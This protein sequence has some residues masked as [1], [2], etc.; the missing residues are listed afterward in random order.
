MFH[1]IKFRDILIKI[2]NEKFDT[3]T[4]FALKS[5]VNRT[6]LSQYINGLLNAPPS[7]KILKKIADVSEGITTYQELMQI[8]G[9]IN[10]EFSI[11]DHLSAEEYA[12]MTKKNGS[13]S[14]EEKAQ[15]MLD[16]ME[17]NNLEHLDM[18]PVYG[19]IPAGQPKLAKQYIENMIPIDPRLSGKDV[20][21]YFY[22][23]VVGNS[24]NQKFQDGD[25]VL[26]REQPNLENGEIGA[27]LVNGDDATIKR[28]RKI[29]KDLVLLEPMSDDSSFEPITIDLKKQNLKI[30]GKAVNYFGSL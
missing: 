21:N 6:Y 3:I 16:Y 25:Y 5:K 19:R 23:K 15:R 8:C 4:E 24:M 18:L 14:L 13:I 2:K 10:E 30:L 22:L 28:Y 20:S 29:S 7:P 27:F 9:Y 11:S 17:K 26:I 1:K 12:E